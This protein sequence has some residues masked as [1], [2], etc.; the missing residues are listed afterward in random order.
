MKTVTPLIEQLKPELKAYF[1]QQREAYPKIIEN[2]YQHLTE[3]YF[4]LDVTY[5]YFLELER[6]YREVNKTLPS[7]LWACFNRP[8]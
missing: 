8:E 2:L 4:V 5:E 3:K 7:N 1:E 6:A